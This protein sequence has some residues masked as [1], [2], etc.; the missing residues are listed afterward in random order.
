M[1][2]T[3]HSDAAKSYEETSRKALDLSQQPNTQGSLGT[4]PPAK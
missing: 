1:A 2:P 3:T 4:T